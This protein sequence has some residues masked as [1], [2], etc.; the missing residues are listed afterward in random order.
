MIE[1]LGDESSGDQVMSDE[2]WGNQAM[3]NNKETWKVDIIIEN[4][5]YEYL[6]TP[7]VVTLWSKISN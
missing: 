4:Q 1:W 3:I 5:M 6:K 2:R 7:K